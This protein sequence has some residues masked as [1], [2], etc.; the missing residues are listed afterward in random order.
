MTLFGAQ[1][2]LVRLELANGYTLVH[3]SLE[4]G[5]QAIFAWRL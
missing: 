5:N 1:L 3:N 2:R 4:T